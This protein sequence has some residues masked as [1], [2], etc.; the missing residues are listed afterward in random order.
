MYCP[1]C[2]KQIEDNA[3]VCPHCFSSTGG[4]SKPQEQGSVFGWGVLGFFFPIVG[5]ILFVIW[6]KDHKRKA[7]AIGIGALI[8]EILSNIMSVILSVVISLNGGLG[9]FLPPFNNG[10]GNG[11]NGEIDWDSTKH[12][13][14]PPD[15]KKAVYDNS[16]DGTLIFR[17]PV[18]GGD[19]IYDVETDS[20]IVYDRWDIYIYNGATGELTFE[21]PYSLT[22]TCASAYGGTLAVGFGKGCQIEVFDLNTFESTIY[23]TKI[24]VFDIAVADGTIVYVDNDQWC[25]ITALDLSN[26]FH[27][28]LVSMYEP[29]IDVNPERGIIY[30]VER[31]ISS[32]NFNYIDLKTGKVTKLASFDDHHYNRREVF[33]DGTF[34]HAFGNIYNAVTGK[35]I[36]QGET[37]IISSDYYGELCRDEC[38]SLI[39]TSDCKTVVYN[40]TTEKAVHTMNLYATRIYA[41]GEGKY[42]A[43]CGTSGYYALIDLNADGDGTVESIPSREATVYEPNAPAPK[44]S[45]AVF[46]NS[47]DGVLSFRASVQGFEMEYD[48]ET[49]TVIAYD[50]WDIYA[51][52]A[53]SGELKFEKPYS[54][55]VT[56]IAVY[57]GTLAVGFGGARRIELFDL[58][59]LESV[60]YKTEISVDVLLVLNGG[61]IVYADGDQRCTI[62]IL[63]LST[64]KHSK[65]AYMYRPSMAINHEQGLLYVAERGISSCAFR[66][67]DLNTLD[68][69]EL[70]EFSQYVYNSKE[71]FFDGAYVHAFG[72]LYDPV[73]GIMLAMGEKFR[74]D[75]DLELYSVLCADGRYTL[76]VTSDCK[77]A[78]YDSK[79]EK[80]IYS[81]DLYATRIHA[82][83]E[84]RY[85][86]LCGNTGYYALIDLNLIS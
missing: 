74:M 80:F 15:I 5:L 43:L 14:L 78:V 76:I 17:M 35:L 61:R 77:T 8:G 18:V 70:A 55:N 81:M 22:V 60:V 59:T 49:N 64:G 66:Y 68:V 20:V 72:N 4:T 56:S 7:K 12:N 19:V 47:K 16:A 48:A 39:V 6:L 86:A 54:L 29:S 53:T 32:C 21:K 67:I 31:H 62:K 13:S 24:S 11:G 45:K 2:G 28:T 25:S 57:G 69:T 36:T 85:L 33:F 82:L 63:D 51:F 42:L 71:V 79:T 40:R 50:S 52:D 37:T 26:G 34:V 23:R 41:L 58:E 38:Y 84:G 65:I 3:E 83:G 9:S 30:A 10:I 73:T 46:E 44:S 27:N 75:T 1:K